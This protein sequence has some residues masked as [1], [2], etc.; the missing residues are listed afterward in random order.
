MKLEF[1]AKSVSYEEAIGGDIIQV[2]FEENPDDDPI[3]PRSKCLSF[4]INHEFPP[5]KLMFEWCDGST[6]YGHAKAIKYTISN[7]ELNLWLEDDVTINVKFS[8]ELETY[9]RIAYLLNNELG[10]PTNA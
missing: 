7:S 10:D 4:S 6:S 9:N 8:T 3:N 5:C 1:K 2:S